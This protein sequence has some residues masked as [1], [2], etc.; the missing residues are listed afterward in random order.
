MAL[1]YWPIFVLG[2]HLRIVNEYSLE[3]AKKGLKNYF[4]IFIEGIGFIIVGI[5]LTFLV[6]QILGFVFFYIGLIC[7]LD[8]F[9]SVYLKKLTNERIFTYD[10]M[11]NLLMDVLDVDKN[12]IETYIEKSLTDYG[13]KM[14]KVMSKEELVEDFKIYQ[15]IV[16][17]NK[18]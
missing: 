14:F 7:I 18:K 4:I 12:I 8:Y 3:E 1:L 6:N 13:H 17:K 10:R 2:T 5:V 11:Y 15:E 16:L 9:L